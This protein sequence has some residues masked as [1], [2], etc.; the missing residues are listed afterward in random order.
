M[1]AILL[2][3]AT[4]MP[5]EDIF[6]YENGE[7]YTDILRERLNLV[8]RHF[9]TFTYELIKDMLTMD[10]DKRPDF[11]S[12]S[13]RLLPYQEDIRRKADLPFFRIRNNFEESFHS[14]KPEDYEDINKYSYE[15]KENPVLMDFIQN[16]MA[17]LSNQ[18]KAAGND[19][20]NDDQYY[21]EVK[22]ETM[23]EKKVQFELPET[24]ESEL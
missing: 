5:S 16:Q 2:A 4:L 17:Q 20:D 19:Y 18:N 3:M 22:S 11:I 23:S 13:N 15:D 24:P 14:E 9:S 7:I 21:K 12:L 8:R 6:D 1:G 10:E